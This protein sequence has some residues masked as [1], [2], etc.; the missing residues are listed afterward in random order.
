MGPVVVVIIAISAYLLGVLTTCAA[1]LSRLHTLEARANEAE[2]RAMLIS[3]QHEMAVTGA[4]QSIRAR[5][6]AAQKEKR[7]G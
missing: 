6:Q 2:E 3:Q 4:F 7:A 1:T 5:A